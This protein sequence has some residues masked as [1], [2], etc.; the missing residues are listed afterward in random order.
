VS[1]NIIGALLESQGQRL[2]LICELLRVQ[3]ERLE[4]LDRKVHQISRQ[5]DYNRS[6]LDHPAGKG[7]Q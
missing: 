2:S 3:T 4:E 7:R 5:L 1:Q 6:R